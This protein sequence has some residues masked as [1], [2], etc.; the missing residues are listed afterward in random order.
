EASTADYTAGPD[1]GDANLD[2][3][4]DSGGT[5]ERA[6]AARDTVAPDGVDI[7]TDHIETIPYEDEEPPEEPAITRRH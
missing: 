4:T 3:D 6:A 7:D 5:G 1:V 2:S